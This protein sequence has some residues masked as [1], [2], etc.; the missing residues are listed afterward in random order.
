M[1]LNIRVLLTFLFT[2]RHNPFHLFDDETPIEKFGEKYDASLFL[3]GSSSKKRPS[4]LVFGRT[5]D[6]QVLDM[7]ELSIVKFKPARE[8]EVSFL[9]CIY[10]FHELFSYYL[11]LTEQ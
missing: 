7:A 3:F 10:L 9:Q 2:C 6:G 11:G 5:H 8:F 4:S 1:Q